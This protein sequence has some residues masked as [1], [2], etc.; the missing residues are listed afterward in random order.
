MFA[1]APATSASTNARY[2]RFYRLGLVYLI[3][4]LAILFSQTLPLFTEGIDGRHS[5]FSHTGPHPQTTTAQDV[6]ILTRTETPPQAI[7]LRPGSAPELRRGLHRI[8]Y[9]DHT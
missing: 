3:L 6:P 9:D 8:D 5:D 1:S 7:I 2:Q 4:A